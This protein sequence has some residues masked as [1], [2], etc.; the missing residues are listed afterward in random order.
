[1]IKWNIEKRDINDLVFY[2]KNPRR[3]TEKGLKDLKKSLERLGDANIITINYDNTVLGGHAR[4]SVMKQLGYKEVDVKVPDRLLDEKEV[5]EVVVRLNA[6]T[7]GEFDNDILEKYYDKEDL[8]EWGYEIPDV[9]VGYKDEEESKYTRKVSLPIYEIR[10]ENPKI[11]DMLDTSKAD[12]FKEEIEK[13]EIPDDVK[14]FLV[15]C[16]TRLYEFDY[17]KIAEYYAHQDKKVQEL[18]EKIALVLIDLNSAVENGY[19][20]LNQFIEN[21][22]LE[23]KENADE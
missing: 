2:D 13:A 7:A 23:D 12:K 19:V 20:E 14:D 1:M 22:F 8:V 11:E 18:M 15:K 5:Q 4:L 9:D 17:G 21:C 6:N 3:F 16:C 10:G